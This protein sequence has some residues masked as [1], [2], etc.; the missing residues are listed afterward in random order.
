MRRAALF[1]IFLFLA[2]TNIPA[3]APA[4]GCSIQDPGFD[5]EK[6]YPV[7]QLKEDFGLLRT[8]LEEG[9]PGLYFYS[10]REDMDRLFN[11]SFERLSEPLTEA[12]F[13]RLVMRVIAGVNDGHTGIRGS[14]S[15][16]RYLNQQ[17]IMLPF[18]LRFLKGKAYLFRNYSEFPELAMGGEVLSING[19]AVPEV[20]EEM[21]PY[22]SSD[23]HIETS[24]YRRL[25]STEYFGQLHALLFGAATS[26]EIVYRMP[27]NPTPKTISVKG[28][29][30]GSLDR[31]FRERYPQAQRSDPPMELQYR[32]GAAVLT[33]RT[34][35][36]GPFRSIG[37]NYPVELRKVFTELDEKKIERLIVDLRGNGGGADM[38]GRLL[39]SYLLDKPFRYYTHLEMNRNSFSFLEHTDSPALNETLDRRLR[40]ND[41]GTYDAVAHPNLG[42]MKSMQPGFRGRVLVLIDGR[43]FSASGECTSILHFHSRADFV[44]E[45]CGAGY[46]GNTSG[47][48]PEVTLPNTRLRLRL[49]L[50][51][52]HMAVSGYG[53]RNRGIIPDYPFSRSISDLLEDRDTEL[54]YALD[55]IRKEP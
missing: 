51:R 24:K 49:P 5:P 29:R 40:K 6:T 16:Q 7:E 20:L 9:H 47:I 39:V 37:T 33:I 50:V 14:A 10:S 55:L 3:A 27:R 19:R 46:Y 38:N 11:S 34:F 53:D 36:D 2:A 41:Q 4:S 12:Q 30:S 35:S 26:F 44:G 21:L 22:V 8:A 42:V 23:G 52:Y 48:M 32:E 43:S 45:E 54:E 17:D 15:Y 28:L 1:L 25:E 18:N 13:L 31:L